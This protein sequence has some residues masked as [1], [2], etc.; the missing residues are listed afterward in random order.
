MA[1]RSNRVQG[2]LTSRRATSSPITRHFCTLSMH[3]TIDTL[4]PRRY[5]FKEYK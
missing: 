1:A 5:V 3:T 4:G 2:E